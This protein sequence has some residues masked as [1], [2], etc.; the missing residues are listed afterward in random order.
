MFAANTGVCRACLGFPLHTANQMFEVL[1][2]Q[3]A[4]A[5][6]NEARAATPCCRGVLVLQCAAMIIMFVLG[7]VCT[8][9]PGHPVCAPQPHGAWIAVLVVGIVG[10]LD[11]IRILFKALRAVPSPSAPSTPPAPI[12]HHHPDVPIA[13]SCTG[14]RALGH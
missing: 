14:S 2:M 3:A 4:P 7:A 1:T 11:S 10:L 9:E 12:V 5:S 6:T 13:Q 8:S